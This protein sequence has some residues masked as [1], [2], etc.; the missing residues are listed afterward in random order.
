MNARS[1]RALLSGNPIVQVFSVLVAGVALIGAVLMGA[2]I[3]AFVLAC[4]VIVGIYF[5]IR[6]RWRLR[7]VRRAGTKQAYARRETSSQA[8]R[9]REGQ[10]R[11]IESESTVIDEH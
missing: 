11:I 5:W 1:V 3:L 8:Q 2:V 4:A 7:S 6:I 10:G 9:R